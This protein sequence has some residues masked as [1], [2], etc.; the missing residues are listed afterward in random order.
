M[1]I[2]ARKSTMLEIDGLDV[3][4]DSIHAVRGVSISVGGGQVV[5]IIGANGAGKTTLLRTISGLMTPGGGRIVYEGKDI[6]G[7]PPAE[8]VVCGIC[9]VP[10]GRQIFAHL[11]VLD[12]LRLGAYL[13]LKG[14][15]RREVNQQLEM[16]FGIFP[17]LR[18]RQK[19]IAGTLSGGE[20]QMVAIGRALMS[21][22]RLLLLDEPSM[23]LAPL[24]VR[25]IFRVIRE[26]HENGTTILLVEQNARMALRVA[27]YGYVLETGEVALEGKAVDLLEN[28]EVERAYL[29]G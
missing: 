12:N 29:G 23:G 25:E 15:R 6:L 19:Q 9:H 21:R 24:V 13:W 2:W 11:S 28:K 22:P 14:G 4:F 10:E 20:Q 27:S 26:L 17:V 3:Y 8:I 7:L 18:E 1:P 16:V 5:S